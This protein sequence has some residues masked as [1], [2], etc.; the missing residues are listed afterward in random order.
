VKVLATIKIVD[1]LTDI[2]A[3]VPD[4]RGADTTGKVL[5]RRSVSIGVVVVGIFGAAGD[6]PWIFI[7]TIAEGCPFP[8]GLSGQPFSRPFGIGLGVIPGDVIDGVIGFASIRKGVE[9]P[10]ARRAVSGDGDESP[11]TADLLS[12]SC[13][14]RRS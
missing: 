6:S 8:L 2:A 12:L 10:V 14:D 3:H 1:P 5:H 4:A 13:P 7:A 9:T 11:C